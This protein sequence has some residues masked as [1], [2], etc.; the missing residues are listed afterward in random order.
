MLP[1]SVEQEDPCQAAGLKE[2]LKAE[3]KDNT[4]AF[5]DKSIPVLKV[6]KVTDNVTFFI[7]KS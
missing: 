7:S 6:Y 4:P 1:A 2:G 5:A 3:A